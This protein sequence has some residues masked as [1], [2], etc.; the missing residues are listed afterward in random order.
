M[1]VVYKETAFLQNKRLETFSFLSMFGARIIHQE[2]KGMKKYFLI[3]QN[4]KIF[5]SLEQELFIKS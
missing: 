4:E 3:T 1:F 2:A 5:S